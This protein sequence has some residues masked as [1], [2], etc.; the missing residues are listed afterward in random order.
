MAL[1]AIRYR[2]AFVAALGCAMAAAWAQPVAVVSDRRLTAARELEVAGQ[3]DAARQLYLEIASSTTASDAIPEALLSLARLA[4]PLEDPARLGRE[5]LPGAMA[6][7]ARTYLETL[8]TKHDRTPQAAEALWRLALL[9]LEPSSPSYD[10]ADATAQLRTLTVTAPTSPRV[11]A[12]LAL[13]AETERRNHRLPQAASIAFSL[14]A[15]H[16][17]ALEYCSG[18]WS[19]LADAEIS[20]LRFGEALNA[21][22]RAA[23]CGGAGPQAERAKQ[24][25]RLLARQLARSPGAVAV[26]PAE[27]PVTIALRDPQ[28]TIDVDGTLWIGSPKDGMLVGIR[29]DRVVEKVP[30][31]GLVSAAFDAW[32]R[33]WSII[34]ERVLAPAGAG[35]YPMPEGAEPVSMAAVDAKA[36]WIADSDTRRVMRIVAGGKIDATAALPAKA[37]PTKLIATTEGGVWVLDERAPGALHHIVPNGARLRTVSLA[38]LATRVVDVARDQLGTLYLLDSKSASVVLISPEGRALQTITL[39]Q[40]G[41]AAFTRP[42]ALAVDRDGSIAVYDS[43][44]GKIAWLR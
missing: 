38:G 2:W 15:D 17:A 19:V 6:I 7:E 13:A 41:D 31:P 14:L 5:P 32:N 8:R 30:L 24:Q 18:G 21:L 22:G 28:L 25:A 9:E 12:A 33:R 43:K 4:W 27:L 37:E 10:P 42:T 36:V 34:G 1:S 23:S 35:D 39:P 29:G 26:V 44:R 20:A 3:A 40:Q 16:P 11:P